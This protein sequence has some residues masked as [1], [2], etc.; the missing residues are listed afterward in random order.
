VGDRLSRLFAG[1]LL[2]EKL[3]ACDAVDFAR[4]AGE[5]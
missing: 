2:G 3:L 1:K 4:L 5:G